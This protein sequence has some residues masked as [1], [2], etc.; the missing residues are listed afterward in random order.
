MYRK[1]IVLLLICICTGFFCLTGCAKKVKE[2]KT[3]LP[4]VETIEEKSEPIEK[5]EKEPM[6]DKIG[7]EDIMANVEKKTYPG[8]EGEFFDIPGLQDC[9][10]EF[11]KYNLTPQAMKIMSEN[12]KIL[13][14]FPKAKIQVEGHCDER[15]TN[16]YNLALGERRASSVKNYLVSLGLPAMDISTISY[17]EEKPVDPGHDED[18]WAKNR[19]AH[20][21]ILS[22]D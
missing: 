15:G 22:K 2:T 9:H 10:F 13:K 16:E 5:V 12:A 20:I 8:I 3:T 17:G 1:R 11:D 7:I 21:I 18:A 6:E 14:N 19:R 4:P